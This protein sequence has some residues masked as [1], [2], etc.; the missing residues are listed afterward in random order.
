[1]TTPTNRD[2]E[3][4]AA[5]ARWRG[6]IRTMPKC[7]INGIDDFALW[8]TPGVAA[9]SRAIAAD[10]A[11]S[12][13]LTGRADTVAIVSDGSR[14][15]G[16][17][18]IGAEAAMPVM[19]GKALLFKHLGAVDAVPLCVDVHDEDA[20][21]AFVHAIAPSFGAVNLEDIA[22]PKCF[23]VLDR[24]Q[25][26]L[27]IPVWHDDQQGTAAAVLAGL[28]NALAVVGKRLEDVSIALVGIGAANHA[29]WRLLC[30]AGADP[31]RIIACDSVGILHI[32]RA[33]IAADKHRLREKWQVC[34][35]T[36][37]AGRTGGVRE[38]LI[39]ADVCIAFSASGPDVIAPDWI[40]SMVPG[41]IVFACANP[42]PEIWPHA[43]RAAGAAIVATGRSDFPN[44]VNNALIFPGL[45]RGVLD[46]GARAITDK[47]AM[48]AA[49]ALADYAKAGGISAA[50]LLPALDDIGAAAAVAGRAGAQAA[51]EPGRAGHITAAT[52]RRIAAARAAATAALAAE[53]EVVQAV[54]RR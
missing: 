37:P 38:A 18:D 4:L 26:S 7:P 34:T 1:V 14:V 43:A 5:H 52:S 22:A 33:D 36:N 49:T 20:L 16:L 46:V 23:R 15:L 44:Q 11:Q 25:A 50:R 29:V 2:P 54:G 35:Q 53:Q 9:V 42:T 28:W 30:A 45:F 12:W 40:A 48:A 41:A 17:G 39:G 32:G 31:G 21:V 10:P 51:G 13:A 3:A 19:E 27:P 47:V 8:Y 6:K 24:L